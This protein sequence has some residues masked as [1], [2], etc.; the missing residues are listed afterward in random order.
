MSLIVL[1]FDRLPTS[2]LGPY[3]N[4]LFSTPAFDDLAASGITLEYAFRA[5]CRTHP[6][7]PILKKLRFPT[8]LWIP[9]P[10]TKDQQELE[11]AFDLMWAPESTANLASKPF[12]GQ[13]VQDWTE[14]EQA[15]CFQSALD[16]IEEFFISQKDSQNDPSLIWVDMPALSCHWDA[17]T[18]WKENLVGEEETLELEEFCPHSLVVNDDWDREL[19]NSVGAAAGAQVMLID[20]CLDSILSLAD[21]KNIDLL[22]TSK[23]GFSLGEH[24][25]LGPASDSCFPEQTQVPLFYRPSGGLNCGV[26]VPGTQQAELWLGWLASQ[27]MQCNTQKTHPRLNEDFENSKQSKDDQLISQSIQNFNWTRYS[28]FASR[29]RQVQQRNDPKTSNLTRNGCSLRNSSI[30]I[31]TDG[32][33]NQQTVFRTDNWAYRYS[34][35]P[36]TG[37]RIDEVFV[38][39]DDRME[40]SDVSSRVPNLADLFREHSLELTACG[41]RWSEDLGVL[42]KEIGEGS[43]GLKSDGTE[44]RKTTQ[45]IDNKELTATEHLPS[46]CSEDLYFTSEIFKSFASGAI[47][48][49]FPDDFWR[50]LA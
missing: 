33:G 47:W 20:H 27:S 24:N 23:E 12:D 16:G 32:R 45:Q 1:C 10:K 25:L 15:S 44:E 5:H 29:F 43:T 3:G 11:F 36:E 17:P 9:N 14:S 50:P 38:R 37:D 34:Q 40:R 39:P 46:S 7:T 26:R 41:L 35:H 30:S 13:D 21:S 2:L 19:L 6:L 31:G 4:T 22:V 48:G 8:S 42:Q 49:V 18:Q 28:L